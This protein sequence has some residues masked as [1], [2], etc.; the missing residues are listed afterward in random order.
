MRKFISLLSAA[1]VAATVVVV[2]VTASAEVGDVLI[3]QNFDDADNLAPWGDA[4]TVGNKVTIGYVDSTTLD[5]IPAA[6]TGNV[7][8]FA[9]DGGN[10]AGSAD[11]DLGADTGSAEAYNIS[12]DAYIKNAYTGSYAAENDTEDLSANMKYV[13]G[14]GGGSQAT[15]VVEFYVIGGDVYIVSNGTNIDTGIDTGDN[16]VWVNVQLFADVASKSISGVVTPSDGDAYTVE[17]M[18]MAGTNAGAIS[19]FYCESFRVDGAHKGY[20]NAHYIYQEAGMPDG[21]LPFDIETFNA[22]PARCTVTSFERDTGRDL[23]FRKEDILVRNYYFFFNYD[24]QIVADELR[25]VKINSL[26]DGR[27]DSEL[28]EL[29]Y[30]R[31]RRELR[32]LREFAYGY[33]VRYLYFYLL[34]FFLFYRRLFH[35]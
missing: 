14:F 20:F 5:G 23:F 21:V 7:F 35:L 15:D 16:G 8:N 1:A 18:A 2:P 13:F 12:F 25:R 17:K 10:N 19:K 26:A 9:S 27:H 22:N 6:V 29:H 3:S 31:C 11:I 34:A 24:V 33:L 28:H 30:N 32:L 4:G